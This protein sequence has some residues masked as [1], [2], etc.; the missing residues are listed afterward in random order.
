MGISRTMFCA[1]F[2]DLNAMPAHELTREAVL[3]RF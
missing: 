2:Q 3:D 1:P